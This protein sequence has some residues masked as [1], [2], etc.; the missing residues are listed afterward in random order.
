MATTDPETGSRS[1]Q[2]PWEQYVR[3]ARDL[4]VATSTAAPAA[5]Q[6]WTTAWCSWATSAAKTH[7]QLARRWTN[8]IEDPG[9]GAE[10]L[11]KM[12]EDMKQYLVEIGTIPERAVLEFLQTMGERGA[13]G[14]DVRSLNDAFVRAADAAT[15]A[16]T[17]AYTAIAEGDEPSAAGE[18]GREAATRSRAAAAERLAELQRKLTALKDAR[19]RLGKGPERPAS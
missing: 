6:A 17:D 18:G 14:S 16:A 13:I 15:I 11:D 10:I 4:F 5:M 1:T 2:I 19:R 7:D 9:Q 12:R 3:D 8:I